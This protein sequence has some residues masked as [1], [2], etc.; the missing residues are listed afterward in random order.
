MS[1][2]TVVVAVGASSLSLLN[3]IEGAKT[4]DRIFQ[5][6]QKPTSEKISDV[7]AETIY[8]SGTVAINIVIACNFK[9]FAKGN[10]NAL[11]ALLLIPIFYLI[12]TLLSFLGVIEKLTEW[13]SS[14]PKSKASPV[15]S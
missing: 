2:Q 9:S 11:L 1:I 13:L 14:S 4:L 15:F 7:I 5:D 10:S 12:Y 3:V 6:T 8:R